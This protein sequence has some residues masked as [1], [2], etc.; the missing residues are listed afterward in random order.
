MR[1]LPSH[2]AMVAGGG[3][4]A[5]RV[6]APQAVGNAA[7]RDR[8]VTARSGRPA[9][10]VGGR[11]GLTVGGSMGAQTAIFAPA[12]GAASR[13]RSAVAS[14]G[15]CGPGPGSPRRGGERAGAQHLSVAAGGGGQA[16]A[17]VDGRPPARSP[18][19]GGGGVA[20]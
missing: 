14:S 20:G 13:W 9:R 4:S 8:I 12:D 1:S 10:S 2:S 3:A 11:R 7:A 16:E 17:V 5:G 15:G 19:R 18:G 6:S